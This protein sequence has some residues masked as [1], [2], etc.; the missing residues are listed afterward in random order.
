MTEATNGCHCCQLHIK[1]TKDADLGEILISMQL[2]SAELAGTDIQEQGRVVLGMGKEKK[3]ILCTARIVLL[4]LYR[5]FAI[6]QRS[7]SYSA[8]IVLA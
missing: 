2:N 6:L 3:H 4:Q 5:P 1:N 8:M 7:S